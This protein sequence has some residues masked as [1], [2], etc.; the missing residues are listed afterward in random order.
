MTFRDIF[1]VHNKHEVTLLVQLDGGLRDHNQF[2]GIR[3]VEG[4]RHRPEPGPPASPDSTEDVPA[5]EGLR[6]GRAPGHDP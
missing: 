3:I 6:A 4:D 1:T 2:F 5:Q